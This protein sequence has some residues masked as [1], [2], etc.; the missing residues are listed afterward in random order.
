MS[1]QNLGLRPELLSAV[2]TAGYTEATPIQ[3]QAIP[4]VLSGR[5][6]LG[7][8]QTGTG[9]TAGF[10]LPL[11]Q[12]LMDSRPTGAAEAP[13]NRP[14][15][16][17]RYARRRQ[18]AFRP[19]RCLIV[20]PTREL[21]AQVQESVRTYGKNLPL[22]STKIFGG[23]GMQPQIDVLRRGVDIVV[24]TPGRL[25]D[26]ARQGIV[27]LSRV[28]I[29]VLDE[30]D[31][32]LDMGFIHDIR[33]ILKLLPKDRQ[34]LLFSA[35]IDGTVKELASSF[36]DRP[37]FI[38]V[39]G[40]GRPAENVEHSLYRVDQSA[41]PA[42][43]TEL[44]R[45][46]DWSRVL[47]F[48][49]T[50]HRANKLA[51]KLERAGIS[52]TAIHGNK[53]QGARTRALADFKAKRVRALVATDIAAR[54]LDIDGLPHVVNYEIPN[55]PQDYIHRIG[56]TGR[57]GASGQAISLI[58][59]DEEKMLRDIERVLRAKIPERQMEGFERSATAPPPLPP[60]RWNRRQPTRKPQHSRPAAAPA[61]ANQAASWPGAERQEPRGPRGPAAANSSRPPQRP[62]R[63]AR[64][65]TPR[66]N[67]QFR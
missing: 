43:L 62:S 4:I 44:I 54:G 31:R 58:S 23:V 12:R 29:L 51:Q 17:K 40:E 7:A 38:K 49:R 20:T 1:F 9:K 3:L 46:G 11:L 35:T 63:R 57:A 56:R 26:H 22:N 66:G 65:G 39:A 41:K 6:L 61:Q 15:G 50:K 55:V 37:A 27:D 10:T 33:K 42:A 48:T 28:E 45:R 25:L 67:A 47:V 14:H 18:P 32:M 52:A 64:R 36:L 19:V 2:E 53:S 60:T 30:A 5:D 13:R 24:A 8:A 34:N 16:N 21:A 59:H